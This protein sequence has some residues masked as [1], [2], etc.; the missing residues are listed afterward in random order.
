MHGF[1]GELSADGAAGP[2]GFDEAYAAPGAPRPHYAP[3]LQALGNQDLA[4]LRAGLRFALRDQGATFGDHEFDM[5]PVPRLLTADEAQRLEAG[6]AQRV[7]ALNAF[8]ADAY[9]E[10]RIA[11]A[12]H[13]PEWIIETADGYEPALAGRW[14]SGA[15]PIGV[16]GLDVVRSAGGELQVLEDN[17]RTPSGFAYAVVAARAL[18]TALRFDVGPYDDG[19]DTLLACLER[20]LRAAMPSR[21]DPTIAVVADGPQN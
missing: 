17:L 3:L 12:G 16:A 18:R 21:D 8:I 4:L 9:G 13:I 20:A 6:L 7:R 5:C 10:R 19:A 14:P 11:A 15:T 1:A 2:G